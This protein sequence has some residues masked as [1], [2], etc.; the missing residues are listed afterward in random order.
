MKTPQER[1]AALT[2]V[3]AEQTQIPM[4]TE[5]YQVALT[6]FGS[7]AQAQ[8][9]LILALSKE[10]F[11]RSCPEIRDLPPGQRVVFS[12]Q[13]ICCLIKNICSVEMIAVSLDELADQEE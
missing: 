3:L 7:E 5:M 10:L 11:S 1:N 8:K 2:E 9:Q 6:T 12:A 4:V 13:L